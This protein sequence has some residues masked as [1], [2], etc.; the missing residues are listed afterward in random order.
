MRVVAIVLWF[1]LIF[2]LSLS[3]FFFFFFSFLLLLLLLLAMGLIFG[4]MPIVVAMEVS[5]GCGGG[6]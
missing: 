3:L 1:S 5:F 4:W 2:S 6:S